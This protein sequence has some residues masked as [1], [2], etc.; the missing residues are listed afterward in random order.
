MKCATIYPRPE[1]AIFVP[2]FSRLIFQ[3]FDSVC[4][5]PGKV[6]VKQLNF[7]NRVLLT[8]RGLLGD[9]PEPSR[10]I[11]EATTFT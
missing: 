10:S 1:K 3:D 7:N 4:Q 6:Y 11:L 2:F 5:P 9:K 8:H